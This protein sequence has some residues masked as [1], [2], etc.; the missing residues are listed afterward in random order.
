MQVDRTTVGIDE[1]EHAGHPQTG[2]T[3]IRHRRLPPM[4]AVRTFEAAARH[5][6]FL[7]A[8]TE[9]HVT[10][11]AVS[12]LVK[13]LEEFLNVEL[14]SR[15]HRS[16]RLTEDGA[17]YAAAVSKAL[18]GLSAATERLMVNS[19][20]NVLRICCHPTFAVHWL[21][22]R[23]AAFQAHHPDIQIDLRTSLAPEAQDIEAF[24]FVV[25]V[26]HDRDSTDS[27][28]V[29]SLR[30]LDVE[31][32][33]VCAPGYVE[34]H[35]P[36]DDPEKLRGHQLIHASLR[37]NDW[38]RWLQSA[39]FH[40]IDRPRGPVFESVALAY[41]AA[42]SG[43]GIAIGIH[44]LIEGDLRAGRLVRLYDHVRRSQSGFN[45][46][47]HASRA[48]QV[49]KIRRFRDWIVAQRDRTEA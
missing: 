35:G 10:P 15:S 17:A 3:S 6:S 24:D 41:N 38:S 36:F 32:F 4:N 49:E 43:A 29:V 11:G 30:L 34:A 13:V 33:P 8:A 42:M 19:N 14:F 20:Q 45:L 46:S 37:P 23:W 26:A 44:A 2:P 12:R 27:S 39:G 28:G 16:I 25:R 5:G 9:L 18:T 7:H 47:F 31:T 40:S 21:V 1:H 22:P 48:R